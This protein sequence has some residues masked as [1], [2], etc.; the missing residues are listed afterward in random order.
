MCNYSGKRD[1]YNHHSTYNNE[2]FDTLK[3]SAIAIHTTKNKHSRGRSTKDGCHFSFHHNSTRNERVITKGSNIRNSL[4]TECIVE[5]NDSTIKFPRSILRQE[6]R[7]RVLN[8]MSHSLH[9][10]VIIFEN[11]Y[12]SAI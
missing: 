6:D 7:G 10:S 8:K 12:R 9:L 5:S 1:K 4:R 11:N 2:V 3:S